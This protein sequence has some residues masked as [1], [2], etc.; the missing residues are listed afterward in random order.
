MALNPFFLQ[1]SSAEQ[2]LIQSLVN[3][4]LK[5]YG[6]EVTYLPRKIVNKDTIFTEIQSSTF[7]DNF[8]I[9][10]YVNTYEGHGGAGDIL[11]KFGVSLKD[12]LII[13][14]SKERFEDFI[15]PFLVSMPSSEIE[16]S[17]RPREGD[18]IYFPL[19]KRIFE[20]KFVEHEKPFYQLG[21]NYVYELRCELFEY[22]D[23]MGGWET[24]T[25]ITEE[26]DE[27]LESQGY[28]TTLKLI[29]I[30]STATVG[31][32][33]STG[34]IRKI[35]LTNDGYGY[36]QV[37][38]VAIST[39]PPGGT[40]ATAVA[41]TSATNNVFSV[42]EILLTNPGS[43]YTVAPT[44]SIV[45]A[46]QTITGVGYTTYGVGAAATAILVTSSAGISGVTINSGGSGYPSA[47]T[48]TFATPLFGIGAA[49]T[50]TVSAAG[51]VTDTTITNGGNFYIPSSP[52]T[53]TFSAPTGGGNETSIVKFG[54]RSYKS[55]GSAITVPTTGVSDLQYGSVGFW[56]YV[57]DN[58]SGNK[59]I[60]EFGANDNDTEK[61]SVR[62][63]VSGENVQAFLY[64]PLNATSSGT[65]A[66][67]LSTNLTTNQWHFLQLAQID[68]QY[69]SR[70]I[71]L[72]NN[73]SFATAS[74]KGN[75]I[76]DNGFIIDPDGSLSDGDVFFDEFY[77]TTVNSEITVPTSTLSG[78]SG[79]VYFQG[80]ERVTATGTATV[81]SGG[82][83]TSITITEPG[84]AYDSAPTITFATPSSGVG[85]AVGRL[86]VTTDNIVDKVFISD[87]GIGYTSGTATATISNPPII[88]GIGTYQYNE[89]VTGSI[90]GAKA[91]V[92]TWDVTTNTLKVGTT[93]GTF[94]VS[95]VI[96]GTSSSA[97]YSV[98]FIESAEFSDKYDKGDEIEQEA[99][100]IV[101]FSESN[102]FGNY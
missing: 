3:E 86:S 40:D 41:I 58:Y 56:F 37:P 20:V 85:T 55:T 18:L 6:V 50:A 35:S 78:Q 12:E 17:S 43:G 101:D 77:A 68:Q 26:I 30:G 27:V 7:N 22:E 4:Q 65:G 82:T 87:A 51:T 21:K 93:D 69:N 57:S 39:A 13:T 29:S 64:F 66:S 99:D 48:I 80:G 96:V 53:V 44:V 2:R 84:T 9:E 36:T 23:E 16:I 14:I 63:Q 100:L 46:G 10:A 97:R 15:S 28:I 19:G 90:S 38:T 98:D 70:Q 88:T 25:A 67:T 33:T 95:D 79:E 45:S 32:T 34:Y 71:H 8:S 5:M 31:V 94:L 102:P 73:S 75:V 72:D 47:P 42:N 62:L 91:R 24:A 76:D 61:Y 60:V 52:P 83:V 81:G 1:G 49:A 74:Y 89:E 59:N 54:S 11:T 92:K